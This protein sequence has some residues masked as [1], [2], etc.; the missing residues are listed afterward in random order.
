MISLGIT[1]GIGSGK[2]VVADIFRSLAYPV[3]D[4]DKVAKNLYD[5]D[6]E[7][8]AELIQLLGQRLYDTPSSK[9]DRKA[10]ASIIFSSQE[11][12]KQINALVHPAVQRAFLSW[13]K[14]QKDRGFQLC[15]LESAI[16]LQGGLKRLLDKIILV[17]ADDD[18]RLER[19]T[20]RDG[21]R[22]EQIRQRMA[23]QMPQSRMEQEVDFVINNFRV[24]SRVFVSL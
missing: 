16:L 12:L 22:Q 9:L 20:L 17:K 8:K 3:F 14:E 21:V 1:G 13:Q 19:A 10:L 18:L 7:L 4:C 24:F 15:C 6:A 2:S 5:E 23:C 11:S